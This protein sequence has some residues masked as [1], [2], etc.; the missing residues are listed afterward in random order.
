MIAKFDIGVVEI[1][2]IAA[3][4]KPDDEGYPVTSRM[5][6]STSAVGY[7]VMICVSQDASLSV[8]IETE[9]DFTAKQLEENEDEN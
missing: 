5:V 2:Q 9:F 1:Q 3:A 6:Y 4:I 7:S 8:I